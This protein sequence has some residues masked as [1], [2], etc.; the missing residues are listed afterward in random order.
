[1]M[2]MQN[3]LERDFSITN[4]RGKFINHATLTFT[5]KQ[6]HVEHLELDK[7]NGSSW[8]AID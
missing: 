5:C 6:M 1:M 2:I 3:V 4:I 7:N 8:I